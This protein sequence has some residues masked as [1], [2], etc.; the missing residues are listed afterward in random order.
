VTTAES[1][2]DPA[3]PVQVSVKVFV[4][5]VSAALVVDPDVGFVP[6]QAPLAVH[7]V[8]FSEDHC[9]TVVPPL[10]TVAGVA[11]SVTLGAAGALT[12]TMTCLLADPPAP[13]QVSV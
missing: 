6:L 9:R 4:D 7:D 12:L 2:A 10:A 8:V 11:V 5:A 13:V 1:L 3:L